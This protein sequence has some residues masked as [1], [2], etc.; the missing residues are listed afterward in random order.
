MLGNWA[1]EAWQTVALHPVKAPHGRKCSMW[2]FRRKPI[3]L[4]WGA[5]QR[6]VQSSELARDDKGRPL[7]EWATATWITWEAGSRAFRDNLDD[8]RDL[9]PA[10]YH[11][12]QAESQQFVAD[13]QSKA[14][15]RRRWVRRVVG[16]E[17][18][19]A[20]LGPCRCEYRLTPGQAAADAA[21]TLARS[22]L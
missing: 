22:K 11:V 8:P 7:A 17:Q 1:V 15:D 2:P 9:C 20:H 10:C 18:R 12:L 4:G 16:A 13:R 3:T 14:A 6:I 5:G 21:R 19:L